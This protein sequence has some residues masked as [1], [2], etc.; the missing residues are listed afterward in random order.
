MPAGDGGMRQQVMRKCQL[1]PSVPKHLPSVPKRCVFG[2]RTP[3]M[4]SR[5]VM[6]RK[7]NKSLPQHIHFDHI[8]HLKDD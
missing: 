2:H 8:F 5:E 1:V 4:D 6:L 3:V 7:P